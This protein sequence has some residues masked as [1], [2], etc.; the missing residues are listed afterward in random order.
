MIK[1]EEL[2]GVLIIKWESQKEKKNMTAIHCHFFP[3]WAINN[4][5]KRD[6]RKYA[7]KPTKNAAAA[8]APPHTVQCIVSGWSPFHRSNQINDNTFIRCH[9]IAKE[10][11]K[12]AAAETGIWQGT[13]CTLRIVHA[14]KF[15]SRICP[16]SGGVVSVRI[17]FAWRPPPGAGF[18]SS[19]I[20]TYEYHFPLF[21]CDFIVWLSVQ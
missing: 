18:Q 7:G 6:N 1:T 13:K 3:F 9:A 16:H 8:A 4:M 11:G 20:R 12:S 21:H 19:C 10:E 5:E 15:P 17:L 2:L 14:I